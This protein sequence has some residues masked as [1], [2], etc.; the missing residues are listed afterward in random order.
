MNVIK[1]FVAGD[2]HGGAYDPDILTYSMAKLNTAN[3]PEQKD[4]HKEDTLCILGDF[5]LPWDNPISKTDIHWLKW[6]TSK[7]FTTIFLGGNHENYGLLKILPETIFH[8][9]KASI[10]YQD[11]NGWILYI[12]RGEIIKINGKK[13]FLFGGAKSHDIYKRKVNID[14]WE[15][16]VPSFSECNYAIDRLVECDNK[17]DFILTHTA[18]MGII[19]SLGFHFIPDPTAYFLDSVKDNVIFNKWFFG[20]FHKDISLDDRFFCHYVNKPIQ[21]F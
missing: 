9:A 5:A 21:L 11:D 12:H 14:Y 3:W 13:I 17:V 8:G 20:H 7:S 19:K 4:L 2:T 18:P 6:F 16:E 15:E 1:F 10:V